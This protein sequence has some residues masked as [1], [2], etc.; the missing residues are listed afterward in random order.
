[1]LKYFIALFTFYSLTILLLNSFFCFYLSLF[2]THDMGLKKVCMYIDDLLVVVLLLYAISL[3]YY[4][5]GID[6][7]N[8]SQLAAINWHITCYYYCIL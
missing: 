2:R 6:W 1:M 3:Y 8:C 7:Q 4:V 5:A